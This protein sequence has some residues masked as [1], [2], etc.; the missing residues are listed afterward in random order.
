[1]QILETDRLTLRP[2]TEDDA[3]LILEL[4]NGPAFI[5]YVAHRGLRFERVISDATSNNEMKLFNWTRSTTGEA[6]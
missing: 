5:E 3:A 4:M 1:M 6:P 2:I